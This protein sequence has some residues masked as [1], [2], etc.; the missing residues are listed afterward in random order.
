M[1]STETTRRIRD[2]ENGG[3][4]AGMEVGGEGDSQSIV[5]RAYPAATLSPPLT[6]GMTDSGHF[7]IK[8]VGS[9]EN[10]FKCFI[11][12]LWGTKSQDSV[13]R[14]Q[15]LTECERSAEAADLN[16]GPPVVTTDW[17]AYRLTA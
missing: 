15:P 8:L 13:H 1:V 3:N 5:I 10:H 2:G 9:D 12:K 16:P 4:G 7:C 14:S 6:P 17:A 11:I